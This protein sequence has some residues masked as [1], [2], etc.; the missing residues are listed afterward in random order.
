MDENKIYMITFCVLLTFLVIL[1][2]VIWHNTKID[3]SF[4]RGYC[5]DKQGINNISDIY[6]FSEGVYLIN[7]S[8]KIEPRIY[9]CDTP[10]YSCN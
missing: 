2:F 5:A 6:N 4:V 10:D 8:N 9:Y 1:I 7:C 3:L